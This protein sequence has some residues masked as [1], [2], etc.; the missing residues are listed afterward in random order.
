MV[1]APLHNLHQKVATGI[2][3]HLQRHLHIHCH[4]R[5]LPPCSALISD[6]MFQLQR[7]KVLQTPGCCTEV[8]LYLPFFSGTRALALLEALA[9]A[10]PHF[11]GNL[12]HNPFIFHQAFQNKNKI[13]EQH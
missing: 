2:P 11:K 4:S 6:L 5:L 7:Q 12:Q 3:N 13:Q 1:L 8:T 9:Q 10:N